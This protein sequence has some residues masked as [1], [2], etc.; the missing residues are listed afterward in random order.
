MV[1]SNLSKQNI[2]SM[3]DAF[4]QTNDNELKKYAAHDSFHSQNSHNNLQPNSKHKDERNAI[5]VNKKYFRS[6]II[7]RKMNEFKLIKRKHIYIL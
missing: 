4:S 1:Q 7:L 2:L 6:L 3:R 5:G